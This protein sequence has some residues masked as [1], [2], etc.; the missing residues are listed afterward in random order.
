MPK[1]GEFEVEE[2]DDAEMLL[3]ELEF[4]DDDSA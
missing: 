4:E 2:D 1:R 3:A